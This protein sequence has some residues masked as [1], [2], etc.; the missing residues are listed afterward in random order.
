[1]ANSSAQSSPGIAL[2]PVTRDDVPALSELVRTV[3]AEFDLSFGVGSPTDADVL[4][5]PDS[6]EAHGGHFWVVEDA[7][8]ELLGSCGLFPLGDGVLELR[9]MYLHPDAR[10][11]GVGRLLME[12]ALTLARSHRARSIV[13]DTLHS[14][15]A[16]CRLYERAGFV[17]DDTQ[18]RGARCNRGYR[19]DL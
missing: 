10:G 14:M 4:E 13:L 11:K 18:I 6:Y 7:S 15:E 19:L 16:A 3:L 12:H 1:M 17:R 2:R 9:K 8:G 5:L